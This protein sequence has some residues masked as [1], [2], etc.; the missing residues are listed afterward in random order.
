[1]YRT[2]WMLGSRIL[3]EYYDTMAAWVDSTARASEV[4]LPSK[5]S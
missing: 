1:M 4:T 3:P 2:Y 5:G